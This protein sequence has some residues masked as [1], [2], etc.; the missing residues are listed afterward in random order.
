MHVWPKVTFS[1]AH[2][3]IVYLQGNVVVC[4]K[5]DRLTLNCNI[6]DGSL[7]G[8]WC[9]NDGETGVCSSLRSPKVVEC[10]P[11]SCGVTRHNG[12]R[13]GQSLSFLHRVS[14]RICPPHH[15]SDISSS[16]T[17]DG[18]RVTSQQGVGGTLDFH[19]VVQ[20]CMETRPQWQHA[21]S[22]THNYGHIW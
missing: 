8:C 20:L 17:G 15:W 1:H 12:T 18:V 22:R 9:I 4:M 13:E 5:T 6:S 16:C 10:Q 14:T 3:I 19:P 21:W 7:Y 11:K 2:H